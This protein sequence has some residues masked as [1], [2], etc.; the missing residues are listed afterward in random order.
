MFDMNNQFKNFLAPQ[1][2]HQEKFLREEKPGNVPNFHY[3][4]SFILIGEGDN[5]PKQ[6]FW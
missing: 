1:Y 5:H 4:K 6:R 3:I 2:R